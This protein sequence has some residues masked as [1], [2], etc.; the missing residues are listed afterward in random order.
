MIG[1]KRTSLAAAPFRAAIFVILAMAGILGLFWAYDE[2]LSYQFTF[3]SIR[4]RYHKSSSPF[5]RCVTIPAKAIISS[6][7]RMTDILSS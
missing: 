3:N 2:Y 5:G 6:G 4:E 7:E 1:E